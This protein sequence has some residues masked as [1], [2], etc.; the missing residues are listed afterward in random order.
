MSSERHVGAIVNQLVVEWLP[1]REV[2]GVSEV[3]WGVFAVHRE[4]DIGDSRYPIPLIV[5]ENEEDPNR[6]SYS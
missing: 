2:G 6:S 5:G 4:I 3:G 1:G